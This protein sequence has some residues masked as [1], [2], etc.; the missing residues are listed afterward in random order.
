MMKN[1]LALFLFIYSISFAQKSQIESKVTFSD[2]R[3]VDAKIPFITNLF[4][5]NQ[6]DEITISDRK[7]KILENGQ[8]IKYQPSEIQKIEFVDLKGKP[9]VFIYFPLESTKT[10]V[11]LVYD[12]RK[13]KWLKAYRRHGYD[14]STLTSDVLYK[15]DIRQPLSLFVN[16]RK[17]LKE[18]TA[19]KPEL[20]PLI[21]NINY[22]RLKEEDLIDLLKR[23]D[24]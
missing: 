18:L 23:Y 13:I 17:K 12:G 24:E 5:S 3:T 7:V 14:G 10:L 8:A 20:E 15:G 6:I 1:L 19:D 2:N 4:D 16:N 22:N 9:R 11:E 21:E